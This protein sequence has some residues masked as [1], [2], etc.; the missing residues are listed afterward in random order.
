[1]FNYK[2]LNIINLQLLF[3]W[4]FVS[5]V[6]LL[7]LLLL[8]T[9]NVLL[10]GTAGFFLIAI[11]LFL[12]SLSGICLLYLRNKKGYPPFKIIGY[13]FSGY[14]FF[15]ALALPAL[16]YISQLS[17]GAISESFF[18]SF[19]VILIICVPFLF[20]GICIFVLMNIQ[21]ELKSFQQRYAV[22]LFAVSF[23]VFL[24]RL[25]VPYLGTEILIAVASILLLAIFAF[26]FLRSIDFKIATIVILS[27]ALCIST[28]YENKT[29]SWLTPFIKKYPHARIEPGQ[30]EFSLWDPIAKIDVID[31]S[32]PPTNKG[33]NNDSKAIKHIFYDGGTIGTKI[34]P[35]DGNFKEL[36]QVYLQQ[37]LLYFTRLATVAAHLL[38]SGTPYKT[39]L[40]GVGA[41]QE[42]K[43]AELYGAKEIYAN[44]LVKAVIDLNKNE[45]SHY[46]GN[47]FNAPEVTIRIGDGRKQI[48][49]LNSFDVIQI[50]SNYLSSN[51]NSGLNY[52]QTSYLFTYES[53][54]EYLE[55]LN[56]DGLLQINQFKFTK[57]VDLIAKVW[58]NQGRELKQ[59]KRHLYVIQ[60]VEK[61]D[62]L[63]TVLFKKSPFTL[64]E[65]RILKALFLL[66][67]SSTYQFYESPFQIE[68]KYLANL[69]TA[70]N[71]GELIVPV[72]DKPYFATPDNIMFNFF[73]LNPIA[74]FTFFSIALIF[75]G[76]ILFRSNF[77]SGTMLGFSKMTAFFNT[78]F[79]FICI[80][81]ASVQIVIKYIDWPDFAYCL[82]IGGMALGIGF[83]NFLL[84]KVKWVGEYRFLIL[85]SFVFYL[86][87]TTISFFLKITSNIDIIFQ[88]FL[89][90]IFFT[91]AGFFGTNLFSFGINRMQLVQKEK[92]FAYAWFLNGI[93]ILIGSIAVQFLMLRQGLHFILM[94]AVILNLITI[95]FL[96][97]NYLKNN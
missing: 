91:G 4:F 87:V 47:I 97:L 82:V 71:I 13:S 78:G 93:G 16:R 77:S 69:I 3:I 52:F 76:F 25:L 61:Y 68:S 83:Y 9:I 89:I 65:D 18:Q 57:I 22:D 58:V 60:D 74:Y 63:T 32:N 36:K 8:R 90:F 54:Q 81:T 84:L 17:M 88:Y 79:S 38:K 5:H 41:G 70:N 96:K 27:F 24:P 7:E 43:A 86:L 85:S 50:F 35:F 21:S 44:E 33:I 42:L 15:A 30:L 12:I 20:S 2:P 26:T 37:P 45:Y 28:I 75:A 10:H 46:N 55:R 56:P 59:L 40:F 51:M 80:Q 34:Y 62:I 53:I 67:S 23:A 48:Q 6:I 72:D 29:S 64:E 14:I 94:L 31:Y 95:G 73:G 49:S 66:K 1:M 11:A 39:Y 92:S 19:F